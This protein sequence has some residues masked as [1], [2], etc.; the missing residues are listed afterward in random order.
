MTDYNEQEIQNALRNRDST[1]DIIS[2]SQKDIRVIF[3][4][5][6]REHDTDPKEDF[7]YY[8]LITSLL[9]AARAN[10][11][12][13]YALLERASDQFTGEE[14]IAFIDVLLAIRTMFKDRV[15]VSDLNTAAWGTAEWSVFIECLP[16]NLERRQVEQLDAAFTK[17]FRNKTWRKLWRRKR[18]SIKIIEKDAALGV[19][20]SLSK[21][22]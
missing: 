22:D 8:D 19:P 11:L 12:A 10:G 9:H 18:K 2:K 15:R 4:Q 20:P 1:R 5:K 16:T 6:Y 3:N 7:T 14:T 21:D 13:P 17:R